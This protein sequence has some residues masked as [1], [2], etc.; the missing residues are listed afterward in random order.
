MIRDSGFVGALV[1]WL[2]VGLSGGTEAAD[3]KKTGIEVTEKMLRFDPATCEADY[4]LLGMG[5]GSA[6]LKML[7]R[8]GG[9]CFFEYRFEVEGGYTVYRTS[10]PIKSGPVTV[11][12]LPGGY[13]AKT[14]FD[15][16][17]AR[18]VGGGS[19]HFDGRAPAKIEQFA[20]NAHGLWLVEVVAKTE[21]DER[22]SDGNKGVRL[23]L[24]PIRGSGGK[25]EML[26]IVTTYGGHRQGPP[27][28]ISEFILPDTFEV[29]SKYWIVFASVHDLE[30]HRQWVVNF[31]DEK[32]DANI[33][34]GLELALKEDRYGWSPTFDP[35]TGLSYGWTSDEKEKLAWKLRVLRGK[36]VLWEQ[37]V[38][39]ELGER[40]PYLYRWSGAQTLA[41]KSPNC[42]K[43]LVV[44]TKRTLKKDNEYQLPAQEVVVLVTYDPESG[45]KLCERLSRTGPDVMILRRDYDPKTGRVVK[46]RKG[47][48]FPK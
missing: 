39:G 30:K 18:V 3:A 38:A 33:L 26:S 40:E 5:Q 47:L 2:F 35:A 25:Q 46:E 31:W 10:V 44:Q 13:L 16:K 28:P 29:G 6:S 23:K 34:A 41:L 4:K 17:K 15:L 11:E 22:P 42:G 36:K 45:A 43:M 1:C 12:A 48:G 37:P 14:S 19:L 20:P 27:P 9:R 7:R 32:P 8:K 21:F 24:R